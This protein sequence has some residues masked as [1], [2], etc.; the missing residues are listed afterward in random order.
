MHI[1]IPM[2]KPAHQTGISSPTQMGKYT[3]QIIVA[4]QNELSSGTVFRRHGSHW[5][6]HND[7]KHIIFHSNKLSNKFF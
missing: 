4:K 3:I 1:A 6:S 5:I 2:V 7:I